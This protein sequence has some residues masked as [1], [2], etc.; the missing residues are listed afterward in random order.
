MR[1]ERYSHLCEEKDWQ[2]KRVESVVQAIT[3][4]EFRVERGCAAELRSRI[5]SELRRSGWSD[6][7]KVNHSTSITITA[8]CGDFGLCLQ[9]GNMSRFYADLLKLQYVYLKSRI[10]SAIYVIPSKRNAQVIGS[11]VAHFER[12]VGELQLFADIVTVPMFVIGID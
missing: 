11:N 12:F 3:N 4:L 2:G 1:I 10:E 9:T 8:I 6:E 5:A 7:V